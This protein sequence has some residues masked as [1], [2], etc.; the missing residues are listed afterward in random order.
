MTIIDADAHLDE[1]PDMWRSHSPACDRELALCVTEDD[2]GYPWLTFAGRQLYLLDTFEVGNWAH[3]GD[4]R[5]RRRAELEIDE[6][7]RLENTPAHHHDPAARLA[8]MD[9]WGI[10]E[11]VLFPNRGFNW[12]AVLAHDI[13]A[14]HVNCAAWNRWAAEVAQAGGGRLHPVGHLVLDGGRSAWLQDQ[15]RFLSKSGIRQA[16]V[17]PGLI[18]GLRPSHP[19]FDPVWQL[20]VENDVAL[21]WHVHSRMGSL[22]DHADGWCDNDRDTHVKLMMVLFGPTAAQMTLA[23]FA[24]NGV[25]HRYPELRV[26]TAELTTEW[27]LALGPRVDG[28]SWSFEQITGRPLDPSLNRSPA[29]YMRAQTTVVCSFPTDVTPGVLRAM[30][31]LPGSFAFATDFPHP[32]GLSTLEEYRARLDQEIPAE[33]AE[34]FFGGNIAAIIH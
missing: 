31:A 10:D 20:F 23:D 24:V 3:P 21:T 15:L 2:K 9:E 16:M 14:L 26:V 18:D 13:D 32:E 12:E 7:H 19:M 5:N 4:L 25:F 6:V 33:H 27:F 11:A 17:C 1:R 22:F 34:G 29:D 28:A 8:K 30:D